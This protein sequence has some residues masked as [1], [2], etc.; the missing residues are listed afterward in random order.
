MSFIEESNCDTCR[1]WIV[2]TE[3]GCP[4]CGRNKASQEK[5]A[6]IISNMEAENNNV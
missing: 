6:E 1:T 3:A 2:P 5:L 4:T